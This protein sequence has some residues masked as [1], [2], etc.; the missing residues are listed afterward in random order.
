M[1]GFAGVG[2]SHLLK[3]CTQLIIEKGYEVEIVAPY[4]NQVKELKKLGVPS[5]TL[6][7]FL[8]NSRQS[9]HSQKV[10]VV[11]EAGLVP[12]HI[13]K[14]LLAQVSKHGGRVV[15][16][17]DIMQLPAIESGQPFAQLQKSGMTTLTLTNIQRQK[18]QNLKE[19]VNLAARGQAIS[20]LGSIKNLTEIKSPLHRY[21]KMAQ[22]Y[23]RLA[24]EIRAD[25]MLLTGTN[26]SPFK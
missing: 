9:L 10:L 14:K 24:P 1:Q 13:M 21:R 7:S 11:D 23:V 15:F 17:G 5:R 3:S 16:L 22:D 2:K 6:I 20:S 8:Q 4:N 26:A 19:A 18:T 25:T 12:T